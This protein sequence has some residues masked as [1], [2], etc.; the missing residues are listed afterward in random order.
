MPLF[1]FLLSCAPKGGNGTVGSA[2]ATT[3]DCVKGLGCST[4][5]FPGGYCTADCSA[6]PCA[7]G[8]VCG[9]VVEMSACLKPCQSRADCRDEYQCFG[10]GCT[11]ACTSDP[12]CGT[13]FHCVSGQCEPYDGAKL[14]ESCGNDMACASRLCLLGKCAQACARDSV[15]TA[16]ETCSLN[17]NVDVI[18]PACVAR[19]AKAAP[20]AACTADT[21][22]DRGNCALG[23]CV[24]LCT[25]AQ[26]C[27]QAGMTCANMVLPLDGA[28]PAFKGC[29]PRTGTLEMS[30]DNGV[31]ALPSNAQTFT[32]Y[33][34]L[35]SFDFTTLVGVIELTDPKGTSVYK[36]PATAAEFFNLL[37]RYEPGEST[38]TMLVPNSPA[39]TL[40]PGAY[41][42]VVSTSK[43]RTKTSRVYIKLGD[44][45]ITTGKVSLNFYVTDLSGSSCKP[46]GQT[47]TAANGASLLA[48][49]IN[50][51]KSII[52]Q[53]GITVTG[54]TFKTATAANV[55][56]RESMG[57]QPSDLDDV[58]QAATTNQGTTVGLDV[59]LVRAIVDS[60]NQDVGIL[61][62]AGGIP[63]SPV[64]GTPHSGAIVRIDTVCANFFPETTA[65]EL[66]H[67]LG[68]FHNVEQSGDTDALPDTPSTG[69]AATQN[70]MYWQENSGMTVTAQQ[71]QVI[72]NDIK[73]RP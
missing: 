22:C 40:V 67:T 55:V 58:L 35:N 17:P 41:P 70:L 45:P 33:S 50:Q 21:D 16:S 64:L 54:V 34:R 30:G 71:A 18:K 48:G 37:V 25:T 15:C 4:D 11:L 8:Q 49:Q 68:L 12:E 73:V 59:V 24:E 10:G 2:C 42:F 47:V 28:N 14:G 66:G 32:I 63:S 23:V 72:R 69:A 65:H 20:G 5:P 39:L 61:G 6:D 43:T 26:D 56:H 36:Q 62:I 57:T 29:L 38:S 1:A 46:G 9:L 27:H 7:E 44:G 3:K 53:A 31:V 51:I 13:G 19:R 60:N 52:S